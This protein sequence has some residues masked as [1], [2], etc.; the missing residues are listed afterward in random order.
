MEP[1]DQNQSDNLFELTVDTKAREHL[2]AAAQ[3]ARIIAI[4][5]F[6]SAGIA[7]LD[8]FLENGTREVFVLIA[9]IIGVIIGSG[10]SVLLYSFLYRFA[11]NMKTGL[12]GMSQELFNMALRNLK[13]YFKIIGILLI[14]AI[15]FAVLY[16]LVFFATLTMK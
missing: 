8:V 15:S 1:V 12:S 6:I 13:T 10:I 5:G 9:Q 4:I 11:G 14:I 3:W 2:Q 7:F 16:L